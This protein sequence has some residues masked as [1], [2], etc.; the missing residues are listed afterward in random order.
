MLLLLACHRQLMITSAL[1]AVHLIKSSLTGCPLAIISFMN[2]NNRC[3]TGPLEQ[4]AVAL[5]C[6]VTC[7][8]AYPKREVSDLTTSPWAPMC[9][10]LIFP[11]RHPSYEPFSSYITDKQDTYVPNAFTKLAWEANNHYK[12]HWIFRISILLAVP[13]VSLDP[14][15]KSQV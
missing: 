7:C 15:S 6:Y 13:T 10:L 1:F 11:C 3:Y 9:T 2:C 5:C 12:S 4:W 14:L 8:P